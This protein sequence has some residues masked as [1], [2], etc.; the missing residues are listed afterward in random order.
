[1]G[2]FLLI[3]VNFRNFHQLLNLDYSYLLTKNIFIHEFIIFQVLS[4]LEKK[5]DMAKN[6]WDWIHNKDGAEPLVS[7]IPLAQATG[8]W[9]TWRLQLLSEDS[10]L[11]VYDVRMAV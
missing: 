3:G 10:E 11:K 8:L 6:C 2:S 5:K 1:M 7:P 4:Y 9:L